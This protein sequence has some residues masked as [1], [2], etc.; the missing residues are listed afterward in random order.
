VAIFGRLTARQRL[1]RAARESLAI[2]AFS[3]PVDCTAWVTGGLWP[4]ELSTVTAETATF[5]E[6]LKADLQRISN[7]ANDEL[8]IIMRAGMADSTRH[9]EEARVIDEARARA[10]R[11]VESTVR[12]L[13]TPKARVPA[14][15]ARPRSD[16]PG[17][18]DTQVLPALADVEP[19]VEAPGAY[20]PPQ[21][22]EGFVGSA[23]DDTQV[24][25]ASADLE[26]VVEAPADAAPEPEQA[27]E[28]ESDQAP[29]A[30]PMADEDDAPEASGGRHRAS[31]D[32]EVDGSAGA[33]RPE[34]IAARLGTEP[35]S[36]RLQR[37]LAF[38]A[39]QEPRLNWAIGDRSDGTT[40]LVTDLAHGWIPSGIRLP[41]GV[42]VLEPERRT[43]GPA[44]LVGDATRTV[45]YAPGDRLGWSADFAP[46]EVSAQPRELPPVDDLT[47]ELEQVTHGRDGLPRMVH[48]LAKAAAHGTRV[49][50]DEVDLLRV[51]LDT[52]FRRLLVQYPNVD[53]A[54]LLN[55]LLLAATEGAVTGDSVSANY[56]LAWFQKLNPP[57]ADL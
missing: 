12:Q 30:S 26:P 46:T 21:V 13:H 3:T 32:D 42:R 43:G 51:H 10:V 15:Y 53:A 35:D 14:G 57:A 7:R 28:N 48:T 49:V 37:L 29:V 41:A 2:P 16:G 34:A 27:I 4:T 31:T 50:E 17:L 40:V 24:L 25:P 52:G 39:R 36:Q 54:V 19:V 47:S 45:I 20:V 6:Y 5:A 56:H 8:R 23:P 9:A 11:R 55:C 18:D 38:V 1:R 22:G 33:L 44:A